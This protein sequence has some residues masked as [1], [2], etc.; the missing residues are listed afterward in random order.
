MRT[1]VE[2]GQLQFTLI[3][4]VCK[5]C[6]RSLTSSISKWNT[7]P[8]SGFL[9]GVSPLSGF[10]DGVSSLSGFLDGVSSSSSMGVYS[11]FLLSL[12]ITITVK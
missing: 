9:D 7:S 3:L 11:A 10:L 2:L 12:T 8:L 6:V 1:A 4:L 5:N